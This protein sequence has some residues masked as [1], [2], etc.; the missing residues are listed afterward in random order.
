MTEAYKK[1]RKKFDHVL[2]VSVQDINDIALALEWKLS[3][4]RKILDS[5][6]LE[7][8]TKLLKRVR[9]LRDSANHKKAM[10]K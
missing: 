7:N 8:I 1:Y 3:E 9:N 6:D 10:K 2:L 4:M 5:K